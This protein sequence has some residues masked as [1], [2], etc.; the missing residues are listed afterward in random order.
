MNSSLTACLLLEANLEDHSKILYDLAC[1]FLGN[2]FCRAN[3]LASDDP[4]T[5]SDTLNRLI[6]KYNYDFL[7]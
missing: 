5:S 1:Y 7:T 3:F 4:K 2:L 6:K